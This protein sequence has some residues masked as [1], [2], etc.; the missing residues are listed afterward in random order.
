MKRREFIYKGI[1]AGLMTG[2]GLHSNLFGSVLPGKTFGPASPYDMVAIRA[3][4][5]K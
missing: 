2:I 3:E 5:Q 1:G 4:K